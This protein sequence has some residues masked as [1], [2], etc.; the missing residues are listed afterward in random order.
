[1]LRLVRNP[2]PPIDRQQD[3]MGAWLQWV[4][5]EERIRVGWHAFVLDSQNAVMYR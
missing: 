1:M 5:E 3:P 2:A 4:V